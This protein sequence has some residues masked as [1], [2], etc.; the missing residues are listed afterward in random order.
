MFVHIGENSVLPI[1]DIVGIFDVEI[2]EDKATRDFLKISEE[3]GFVIKNDNDTERS[4]ILTG[5]NI[6]FSPIASTTL[7]KRIDK[8]YSQQQKYADV[9]IDGAIIDNH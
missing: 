5:Q 2:L 6:Y 1:K 7:K 4:F 9:F 8:L 3:E